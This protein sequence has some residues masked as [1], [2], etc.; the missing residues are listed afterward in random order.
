MG[1]ET[2]QNKPSRKIHNITAI[3][4]QTLQEGISRPT[5][6]NAPLRTFLMRLILANNLP[7]AGLITQLYQRRAQITAHR[8]TMEENARITET[9]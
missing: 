7:Q 9:G 5:G 6:V 3:G 1:L 4:R 2:R 8:A